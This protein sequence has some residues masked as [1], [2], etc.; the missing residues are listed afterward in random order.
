MLERSDESK[1][2][3]AL[4]AMGQR[5]V[6]HDGALYRHITT[7]GGIQREQLLLPSCLKETTLRGLH[8]E[9]GHQGVE[10]T[11]ALVRERCYWVGL[12]EDVK[13]WV[14]RCERCTVSKMPQVKTKTPMGR[15][16]ATR[17]LEV[18]AIDFTVLE[19]ASDGRENVLV[20]TDVFTKYTVAV[21]TR[22]QRADTVARI[23]VNE[24]F[25]V[26]GVPL[27]IHSD[28][29]RNFESAFIRKLSTMYDIK[30]SHTTP[31]T[32]WQHW[33][34]ATLVDV[35][36]RQQATHRRATGR[37]GVVLWWLGPASSASAA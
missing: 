18:L 6:E 29:G 10:R 35:R 13:R 20:I 23:L 3:L 28:L 22:N 17:P 19:P 32:A 27:R 31:Y 2:A 16:S 15:L 37:R 30:K 33:L 11:E 12:R 14:E 7:P 25:L 34:F 5:I 21:P 9:A 26:F 8:D 36:A 4:L 24:W 1:A